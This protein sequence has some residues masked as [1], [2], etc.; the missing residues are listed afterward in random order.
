[1]IL[2]SNLH[3]SQELIT[4]L[5]EKA[6]QY[7][8]LLEAHNKGTEE[9]KKSHNVSKIDIFKNSNLKYLCLKITLKF[10]VNLYCCLINFLMD[11]L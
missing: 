6:T 11:L 3:I 9:M 1:M 10:F 8:T 4:M 7:Y 5:A 2:D